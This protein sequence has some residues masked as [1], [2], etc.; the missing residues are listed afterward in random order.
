[1]SAIPLAFCGRLENND[2]VNGDIIIT[3]D[4]KY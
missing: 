1:M 3:F 4:L 2:F